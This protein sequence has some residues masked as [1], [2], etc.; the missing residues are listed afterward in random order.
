MKWFA[1]A[2]A[3]LLGLLL[4]MFLIGLAIPRHHSA[5]RQATYEQSPSAL[6]AAIT[7]VAEFQ[8]WRGGLKKVEE[9][10][11]P[12]G[13][14]GWVE[15]TSF[16]ELPLE[17][18]ESV[19]EEKLVL[20]I[21]SEELPFGGTWS[22]V[23]EPAADGTRLTITEEGEIRTALFRFM[24]RFLFGYHKTLED[25]LED[26]GRKFGEEVTPAPPGRY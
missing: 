3:V 4:L 14:R 15:T 12:S 10:Q 23:L 5:A 19:P 22:Y 9:R 26:L 16:G 17:V 25:Y 2:L 24:A 7:N 13:N 11:F 18:V 6:W 1:L 21:A 8:S 20:R